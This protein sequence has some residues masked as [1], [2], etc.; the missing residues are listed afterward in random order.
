MSIADDIEKPQCGLCQALLST[1]SMKPSKPE[2]HLETK[3]P[4]HAKKDLDFF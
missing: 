3:H 1:G 4:E 2:R